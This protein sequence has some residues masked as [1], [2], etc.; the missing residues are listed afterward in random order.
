MAGD[1][2][3]SGKTPS[4]WTRPP[5]KGKAKK[6]KEQLQQ[7]R[8]ARK[9]QKGRDYTQRR[10]AT[11]DDVLSAMASGALGRGPEGLEAPLMDPSDLIPPGRPVVELT[12][13]QK[14]GGIQAS[15]YRTEYARIARSMCE[16]GATDTQVAAALGISLSTMWGWQTRHP[17]FFQ[18]MIVGKD[19]PD[20]RVV[21]ALYQRAVGMHYPDFEFKTVNGELHMIPV[22][23]YI[24]G[25]VGAQKW[26][27]S[28]R[29]PVD[30]NDD[31]NINLSPS[32]SFVN[33]WRAVS[34][35]QLLP[36]LDVVP[37]EVSDG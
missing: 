30:W 5:R 35:G 34:Q 25:D 15:T 26:W 19:L 14:H 18:A 12:P 27:L 13:E 32:E 17:D 24:P 20:E 33:L 8:K 16:L 22:M 2:T 29:R 37:E 28:K 1:K 9:Q 36:V 21:R 7:E 4:E 11:H 6:P 10:N 3:A 23:R 31:K